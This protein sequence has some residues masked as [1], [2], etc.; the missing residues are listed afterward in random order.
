MTVKA[1]GPS[2]L[3]ILA[4]LLGTV[5]FQGSP[6]NQ[7]TLRDFEGNEYRTVRIGDQIWMSENLRSTRTREGIVVTSFLPNND[8]SNIRNYGRLYDWETA[9]RIAPNGWHLPSDTEW[10]ALEKHLGKTAG[11]KLKDTVFWSPPNTGA[12]NAAAFNARPAGYWNEGGFD[13][14]FG[15]RAVFWSS[16]KQNSHFVWSRTL[17]YDHDSLRRAPQHPQY[18]FSVRYIKDMP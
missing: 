12:T 10:H 9:I 2:F 13:N 14:N 8:S 16:T 5:R 4:I 3:L 18:G 7:N 17:S 15:L 6:S 1:S 11:A